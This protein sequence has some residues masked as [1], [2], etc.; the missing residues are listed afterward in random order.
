MSLIRNPAFGLAVAIF[1][2]AALLG[3]SLGMATAASR[4]L[5]PGFN[6]IS[7]PL[8]GDVEP[9]TFVSCLPPTSWASLYVWD[10]AEQEWSHYFN[11]STADNIPGFVN[12]PT[13]GGIDELPRL[14]GVVIYISQAIP[15]EDANF[16]EA[17]GSS[18]Q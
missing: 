3:G 10:S 9:E 18:C 13:V 16:L 5:D 7:G 2:I 15:S 14:S 1:G 8:S 6:L 12:D 11:T 4:Q 17:P